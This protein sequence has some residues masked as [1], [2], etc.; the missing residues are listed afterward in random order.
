MQAE[1]VEIFHYPD[2]WLVHF[3]PVE[4]GPLGVPLLNSPQ[5]LD[6][7]NGPATLT[8]L[9]EFIL[10]NTLESLS[11]HLLPLRFQVPFD[12]ISHDFGDSLF[13]KN[14]LNV[15]GYDMEVWGEFGN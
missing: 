8:D 10:D 11:D 6:A 1:T 14:L 12:P 2:K 7:V 4:T 3:P 15:L 9:P 13:V 5:G